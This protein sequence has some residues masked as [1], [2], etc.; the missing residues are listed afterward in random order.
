MLHCYARVSTARQ[1][2][3]G[4]VSISEQISQCRQVTATRGLDK[5]SVVDWR[6]EGVSG[7]VPLQ[8]RPA[9]GELWNSLEKGD[10]LVATKVD[11]LFRSISNAADSLK[12]L[13]EDKQVEVII[14]AM[15]SEPIG[16]TAM[17]RMLFQ[18][19]S[20]FGEFEREL[21]RERTHEGRTGKRMR[22]GYLGGSV[23]Y[24]YRLEGEGR[25]AALIAIPEEQPVIELIMDHWKYGNPY[26]ITAMVNDAGY[27]TRTGR[28]WDKRQV[29]RIHD[30]E[31]RRRQIA[32][33]NNG[34][35]RGSDP[36]LQPSL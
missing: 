3:D 27:R 30:L 16:Q 31:K 22:N 5:F 19:L 12:T 34:G 9:G 2:A 15:G 11:R 4:T 24:G 26:R 23:P 25:Q 7:S 6:D 36:V 33:R 28:L 35:S 17:G 1:H 29:I 13:I 18:M 10:T 32:E 8:K 20:V 21:I 14:L